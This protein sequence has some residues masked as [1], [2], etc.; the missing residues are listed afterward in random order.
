YAATDE[1]GEFVFTDLAAG[2]YDLELSHV[3]YDKAFRRISINEGDTI[4]LTILL[5]P[6]TIPVAGLTVTATR[7][8]KEKFSL[9][10]SVS[11]VSRERLN[12][13]SF[14]TTGEAL[15]EEPG[16]LVQKTTHGHGAPILRGLIGKRVLLLYDGIRLNKPT[17]RSGR[18]QYLSTI[19]LESFERIEVVRGPSSVIYGSDCLGGAVNLI[20][21]PPPGRGGSF[22]VSPY[23]VGRYSS[24]DDGRI[25]HLRLTGDHRRFTAILGMTYKKIGDLRAG[26]NVRRQN[27]TG[28]EEGAVNA[29][30]FAG[31]GKNCHLRL[32]YL[33]VR[34]NRV[35]RY[36]KY[37]SGQFQQ[38]IYDPQNRDLLALALTCRPLGSLFHSVKAA[39]S[40]QH[41]IEGRIQ[42]K[43]G[44]SSIRNYRDRISTWGGYAQTSTLVMSKHWLSFGCEYYYDCVNSEGTRTSDG[45]TETIRPTFPDGST[46]QSAGLFLHDE[47]S[48][49][50]NLSLMGGVH[51]SYFYLPAPRGTV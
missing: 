24:A 9:P 6:I 36:D 32:D 45:E 43:A 48:I 44:S 22:S 50:T 19:D 7:F 39:I 23:L 34:Q 30:L 40:Y 17:F 29:H 31:M 42:Q 14:S 3:G 8:V 16:I 20:P 38:Y 10:V 11:V 5:E 18:N 12:Q 49:S 26:R 46:Y 13:R 35:P 2:S 41:E 51:Y 33:A 25:V 21:G 4:R 27:P 28:W 47:Y 37:V 15:R 1:R